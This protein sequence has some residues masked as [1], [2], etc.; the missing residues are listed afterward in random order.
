MKIV[1]LLVVAAMI[2]VSGVALADENG[3]KAQEPDK[4]KK[5]CR[6]EAETGSLLTKRRVCRTQA[7]WDRLAEQTE[8]DMRRYDRVQ[9]RVQ[10]G[11][12]DAF[13]GGAQ[14]LSPH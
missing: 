13:G 10:P 11:G 9:N 14:S 4:E 1:R 3:G 2:S 6:S 5:V 7:E 8:E 12:G